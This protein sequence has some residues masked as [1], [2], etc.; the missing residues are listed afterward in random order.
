T[1]WDLE[2]LY[3]DLAIVKQQSGKRNK[4]TPVEMACLRGLLCGYGPND[5]AATLNREPRGLRVDF[6]RG[7]YRYVEMLTERPPNTLKDWR[8]V[9]NWLI[10]VGYQTRSNNF[11]QQTNDSLIKIVDIIFG[12]ARNSPVIDIKV[13]NTGNQVAF[14]K[15]TRFNFYKAWY[16]QSWIIQKQAERLPFPAARCQPLAKSRPVEPSFNY[17]VSIEELYD[18]VE[19]SH[20]YEVEVIQV[21]PLSPLSLLKQSIYIEEFNISQ[22]VSGND[23]DRFTFTLSFPE[24]QLEPYR[25]IYKSY[26]YHLKLEIVYDEDDKTVQSRDLLLLVE[27][28]NLPD[29]NRY[30]FEKDYLRELKVN[31][32]DLEFKSYSQHNQEVLAEVAQIDGVRSVLLNKLIEHQY[33]VLNFEF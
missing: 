12:G 16:L 26:V 3:R 9:A 8:D 23:V 25:N 22:C 32:V 5:I 11:S 28:K 31:Q 7:L 13:R 14:L 18:F 4:L 1:D 15:K 29:G 19:G 33:N 10:I 30:F 27:P 20:N 6:C 21:E 2:R 17:Q 24:V